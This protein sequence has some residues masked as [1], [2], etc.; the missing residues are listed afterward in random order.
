MLKFKDGVEVMYGMVEFC[1][2]LLSKVRQM[3]Y[4]L[5]FDFFFPRFSFLSCAV[6][7]GWSLIIA[8]VIAVV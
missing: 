5:H 6:R 3:V 7:L 2:V 1:I 8:L 4:I